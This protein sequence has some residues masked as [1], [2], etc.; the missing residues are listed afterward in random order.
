M[1]IKYDNIV[2]LYHRLDSSILFTLVRLGYDAMT[3][4]FSNAEILLMSLC[5]LISSTTLKSLQ[6]KSTWLTMD[7][8]LTISS[9]LLSQAIVKNVTNNTTIF[10]TNVITDAQDTLDLVAITAILL[11]AA[12]A[13]QQTRELS[14]VNQSVTLILYMYTDA[15]D[16]LLQSIKVQNVVL[17]LAVL[18]YVTL[19]RFGSSLSKMHVLLYFVKGMSMLS[20]N[21][22]LTNI[23]SSKGSQFDNATQ[24]VIIIIILFLIDALCSLTDQLDEA[25]GFAVWKCAQLLYSVYAQQHIEQNVTFF[26]ALI[27][28]CSSVMGLL[29]RN[30]L[31]QLV[32]LI[33]VNA[34]LQ[35]FT[36]TLKHN[37]SSELFMLFIAVLILH[38]IPKLLQK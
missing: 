9:A 30:T 12:S 21:T 8:C 10:K 16:F 5:V 31:V 7:V 23:S 13:P 15:M 11:F 32:M 28:F 27:I 36:D 29:P 3:H 33:T 4:L 17:S 34:L 37:T 35:S 1:K 25:K 22:I 26:L 6:P 20:V 19:L 2:D 14:F 18:I 24:S 38:V